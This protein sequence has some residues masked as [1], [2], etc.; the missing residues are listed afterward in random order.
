MSLTFSCRILQQA[1]LAL[2]L[3]GKRYRT[4][5]RLPIENIETPGDEDV[6][7]GKARVTDQERVKSIAES[8]KAKGF[9]NFHTE[10]LFVTLTAKDARTSDE[11]LRGLLDVCLRASTETETR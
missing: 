1:S 7:A 3:A 9:S 11:Q 4:M 10:S 8:I 5:I 2:D 6:G